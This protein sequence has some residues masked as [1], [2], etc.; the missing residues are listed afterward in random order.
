MLFSALEQVELGWMLAA[1][2][3]GETTHGAQWHRVTDHQMMA[4]GDK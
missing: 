4:K 3:E 1:G 2:G